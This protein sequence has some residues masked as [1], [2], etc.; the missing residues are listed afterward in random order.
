MTDWQ[1]NA[2][3]RVKDNFVAGNYRALW[4]TLSVPSNK[5]SR[6]AFR[7]MSLDA[8]SVKANSGEWLMHLDALSGGSLRMVVAQSGYRLE[9]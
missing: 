4:E 6:E 5:V 7:R 8:P 2:R 9:T 1:E 3:N